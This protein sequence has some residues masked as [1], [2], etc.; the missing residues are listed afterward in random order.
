MTAEFRETLATRLLRSPAS[1]K[2]LAHASGLTVAAWFVALAAANAAGVLP[3]LGPVTFPAAAFVDLLALAFVSAALPFAVFEYRESRRVNSIEGR[4]PDLLSDLASLHKAGLTL[5]DALKVSARGNYGAL[6]PEVRRASAQVEWGVPVLDA[7]GML[8]DRL[9]TPVANRTLTVVIEAGHAGGR[10][11]DVLVVAA[12]VARRLHVMRRQR[13]Q[14]ML[15]YLLIV[16]VASLVF[17]FVVLALQGVFVPRMVEAISG[18]GGGGGVFGVGRIPA[19]GDFRALY[20]TAA[21]VQAIGNGF[22]GGVMGEG[23][24]DAGAKHAIV[25]VMISLAGFA[26]FG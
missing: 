5:M 23:R 12:D 3:A 21:M 13:Q 6:T 19:V 15:L 8:R 1:P 2:F 4:L 16:Y 11:E 22:V 17:L 24:A 9:R 14:E 18:T 26:M 25:M 7:L 10:V 20:V